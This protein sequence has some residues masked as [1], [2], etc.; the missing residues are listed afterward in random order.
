M[1]YLI[2]KN[3]DDIDGILNYFVD[4]EI[5]NSVRFACESALLGLFAKSTGR[6]FSDIFSVEPDKIVSVCGLLLSGDEMLNSAEELIR[7]GYMAI[8]AKAGG[9]LATDIKRLAPLA[10]LC[11]QRGVKL[12]LDANR[13][14]DLESAAALCRELPPYSIDYFEEP[15][16]N[17]DDL[18][19]F[20][21]LTGVPVALDE[22]V[23]QCIDLNFLKIPDGTKALIIKPSAV[24]SYKKIF[25]LR[26]IATENNLKIIL[27]S[28]F[29]TDIGLSLLL[30]LSAGFNLYPEA[31]G[32]DTGKWFTENLMYPDGLFSG[33][34]INIDN[35]L[36]NNFNLNNNILYEKVRIGQ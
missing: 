12:R 9:D 28:A 4:F 1:E 26:E 10:E 5:F 18:T 33:P 25:K 30:Q 8:K 17:P 29:E 24:G 6:N 13:K 27:S 36:K 7:R 14:Y 23:Y 2:G 3:F 21:Q 16:N 20:Y 35:I 15:V 22:S 31:M 11:L 19:R 32:L 34:E